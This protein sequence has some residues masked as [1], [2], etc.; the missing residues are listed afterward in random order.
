MTKETHYRWPK[1]GDRVVRTIAGT[2]DI[3]RSGNIGV[4]AIDVEDVQ[5]GERFEK[6]PLVE[7]KPIN[8][9]EC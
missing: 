8:A 4:S 1:N 6:V 9:D 5:T 7:L 3:G 2:G